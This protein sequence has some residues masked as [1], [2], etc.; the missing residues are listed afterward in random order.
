MPHDIDAILYLARPT[1]RGSG[2]RRKGRRRRRRQYIKNGRRR[3]R[4]YPLI[5]VGQSPDISAAWLIRLLYNRWYCFTTQRRHTILYYI[6][7]NKKKK[8]I[9]S[10]RAKYN[11][12]THT[13]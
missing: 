11:F 5:T 12:I 2:G 7:F 6:I 1:D 13:P 9:Y 8:T 10:N 4:S 3:Q